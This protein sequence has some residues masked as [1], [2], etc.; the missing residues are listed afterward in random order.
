MLPPGQ[1]LPDSVPVHG[2]TLHQA[3]LMI[4]IGKDSFQALVSQGLMPRP[5]M[6]GRRRL[7]SRPAV[8]AAFEA[9][10]QDESYGGPPEDDAEDSEDIAAGN[11]WD[12]PPPAL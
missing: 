3:A 8:L 9:L 6:I 12:N 7:W 11:A 2:L 5:R 4:G 10:P 1:I